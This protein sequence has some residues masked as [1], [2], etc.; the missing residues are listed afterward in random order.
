MIWSCKK[1]LPRR[2]TNTARQLCQERI[3]PDLSPPT[4]ATN[5]MLLRGPARIAAV[6]K[7]CPAWS[8]KCPWGIAHH[9]Q[10]VCQN[11]GV[12]RN[13]KNGPRKYTDN[14]DESGTEVNFSID[15]CCKPDTCVE[16]CSH[17]ISSGNKHLHPGPWKGYLHMLN[18]KLKLVDI[19][20]LGEGVGVLNPKCESYQPRALCR[21]LNPSSRIL[22]ILT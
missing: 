21:F 17:S 8:A 13:R 5:E 22:W 6:R 1:Q 15:L 2:V 18:S 4:K 11:K 7:E 16:T 10:R 14:A 19:P 20:R 9:L 3:C 12:P